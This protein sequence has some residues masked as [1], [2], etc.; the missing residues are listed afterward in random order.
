MRRTLPFVAA[1]AA[2]CVAGAGAAS[3]QVATDGYYNG[4]YYHNGA[5]YRG[6]VR[7]EAPVATVTTAA[8]ATRTTV[9]TSEPLPRTATTV[10][11]ETR[12]TTAT[13]APAATIEVTR[14]EP[15]EVMGWV[16][17]RPDDCGVYHYWNGEDCIDARDVPP[18][19]QT[20]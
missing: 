20:E 12:V 1:L 18:P 10:T 2:L 4:V 7:P 19:I 6:L 8:P 11:R 17:F 15:V 16:S 3:A 5:F 13:P 14:N 9:T